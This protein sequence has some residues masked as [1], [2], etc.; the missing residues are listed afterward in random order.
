MTE[1]ESTSMKDIVLE[2]APVLKAF[3]DT[4]SQP[5][6]QEWANNLYIPSHDLFKEI[7]KKHGDKVE[8][9]CI[10]TWALTADTLLLFRENIGETPLR[11]AETLFCIGYEVGSSSKLSLFLEDITNIL[12]TQDIF[13]SDLLELPNGRGIIQGLISGMLSTGAFYK[14]HQFPNVSGPPNVGNTTEV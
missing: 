8:N 14:Y 7:E 5:G 2:R 4:S 13:S 9:Y 12:Q 6:S 11:V 3:L 10:P 1:F